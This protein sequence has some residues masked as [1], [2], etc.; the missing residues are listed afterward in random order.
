MENITSLNAGMQLKNEEKGETAQGLNNVN[1]AANTAIGI[2]NLSN[3]NAL[4]RPSGIIR[5][6]K[7]W[8]VTNLKQFNLNT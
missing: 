1:S 4:L 5:K 3:V 6:T 2:W 8:I 7:L